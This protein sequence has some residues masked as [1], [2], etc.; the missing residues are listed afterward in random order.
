[1]AGKF[2]INE[3]ICKISGSPRETEFA[4]KFSPESR[5]VPMH[6]PR[7]QEVLPFGITDKESVDQ[8]RSICQE[9]MICEAAYIGKFTGYQKQIGLDDKKIRENNGDQQTVLAGEFQE[10]TNGQRTCAFKMAPERDLGLNPPSS[11]IPNC[12][13]TLQEQKLSSWT[14]SPFAVAPS[15]LLAGPTESV[16]EKGSLD[17][18]RSMDQ[19]DLMRPTSFSRISRDNENGEGTKQQP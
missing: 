15:R 11:Q 8:S 13:Q 1:L 12:Y 3:D 16:E 6:L 9:D 14:L 17:Q 10:R 5:D 4:E 2:Q 7:S 18:S 19:E